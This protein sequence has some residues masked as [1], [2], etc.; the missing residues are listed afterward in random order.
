MSF[1]KNRLLNALIL[2]LAWFCTWGC[3]H[4]GNETRFLDSGFR[5]DPG[6]VM[7]S[8][9][10]AIVPAHYY[11]HYENN[12]DDWRKCTKEGLILK[13]TESWKG[14]DY[15][16]AMFDTCYG[17]TNIAWFADSTA[18]YWFW[19][20]QNE[21]KEQKYFIWKIGETPIEKKATW[22]S[23]YMDLFSSNVS[24]RT[25]KDGKLLFIS[26]DKFAL[27]DTAANTI[28]QISKEDAGWPDDVEDAQYFGDDLMTLHFV[29]EKHCEFGI[30]RNL[31]DSVAAH[32]EDSCEGDFLSP[33]FNGK[34]ISTGYSSF[35]EKYNV[36]GNG[37]L[38]FSTDSAWQISEKPVAR[39]YNDQFQILDKE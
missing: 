14:T 6:F 25:W 8:D 24:V 29:S 34:Y 32:R 3:D 15:W 26:Y 30:M 10:T 19:T 21:Y 35:N 27:L 7:V 18:F 20:S 11:D 22:I 38:I 4:L 13:G 1:F 17:N 36:Y 28:T 9:T 31:T 37:A 33:R 23:S 12:I 2:T 39:Y 5:Q 16:E